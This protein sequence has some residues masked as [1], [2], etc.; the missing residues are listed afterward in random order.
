VNGKVGEAEAAHAEALARV[1]VARAKAKVEELKFAE[2]NE[3]ANEAVKRS[4]AETWAKSAEAE[5]RFRVARTLEAE[6]IA[7]A[8]AQ[9]AAK[10]KMATVEALE[11]DLKIVKLRKELEVLTGESEVKEYLCLLSLRPSLTACLSDLNSSPYSVFTSV[12]LFFFLTGV[13]LDGRDE[14]QNSGTVL[15]ED[16]E[17]NKQKHSSP[18]S[19]RFSEDSLKRKRIEPSTPDCSSR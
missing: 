5:A 11:A 6:S 15:L 1:R 16:S 19:P 13:P 14:E 18:R 17:L 8:R 10:V 7:V 2:A 3:L 4:R 9:R 12:F